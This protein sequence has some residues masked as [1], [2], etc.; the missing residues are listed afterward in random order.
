MG[1]SA[2]QVLKGIF[3][4]LV[5]LAMTSCTTVNEGL[6][7]TLNLD[8]DLKLKISASGNINPDE[9][10]QASPVFVRLYELSSP[11]AFDK[12]NFIDLYERDQ[13]VLGDSFIAKQEL[14]RVVPGSERTEHFV[15]SEETRYVALFAEFY[16]Y[17]DSK[18][19]VS[20]AVT[21]NNIVRN[22]IK[23]NINANSISVGK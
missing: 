21:S 9:N 16:R 4:G 11:L 8:T 15:L 18:A 6:A 7:G 1:S 5:A 13:E 3:I 14:K 17:K 20:F 23:V 12:A 19:K 2:V 22:S 10:K